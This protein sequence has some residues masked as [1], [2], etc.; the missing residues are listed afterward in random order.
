[1]DFLAKHTVPYAA[2]RGS[3][4]QPPGIENVTRLV[5]H[6]HSELRSL[7]LDVAATGLAACDVA[8][9]T[10]RIVSLDGDLLR[11]GSAEYAL[12]P[13]GRVVVLGAGKASLRIA[14]A[15]ERV[16]A[17]RLSSG[18][19]VAR[20]GEAFPLRKIEVLSAD[21]PLPTAR[22]VTAALR[23]LELASDLGER[24]L[25]LAC[26]TGGSSSL[27]SLPPLGVTMDEKTE[28]HRV[29]LTSGMS[30]VEV[31]SVRK[32]VS[33]IK[34]G[35]LAAIAAPAMIVNLTASDV[36]GNRLDAIT[37]PTV[38][39]TTTARDAV[40][41]LVDYGVWDSIPESVRSHL[42][43]SDAESPSL[44][45]VD[46]H[47]EVTVDG[48]AVCEAMALRGTE[49]GITSVV[50]STS[51]EGEARELGGLIGNLAA[52]SYF[53]DA[54]FAPPC[55]L[56]GCGGEATVTLSDHAEF[57][58]GGPNQEAALGFALALR[59]APAVAGVFLDTDGADGGTDVAG[60]IADGLGGERSGTF[61]SDARSALAT[62]R[63]RGSLQAL[64]DLVVTGPT[65]T[66]LN[67]L[68]AVAVGERPKAQHDLTTRSDQ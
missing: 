54:P 50:I 22:S 58:A 8:A 14:A 65:G 47:S 49:R 66:N 51:L 5:G 36:A 38:R 53:R 42:G 40:D 48:A 55:L 29:L 35:R 41:I 10:E 24:D 68:F 28:L 11:V 59:H 44:D 33:Q 64:D 9:A 18:V 46:I 30:I 2:T 57:G 60:G 20:A 23:L 56:L 6:G 3:L 27:A 15:L 17:Q 12:D 1:V 4:D 13:A 26:F 32:H 25:V 62:H 61:E 21:H 34:G 16:L 31:N 7:V 52:E 45:G 67:D 43:G 39:D 19:V 37:D 63:A